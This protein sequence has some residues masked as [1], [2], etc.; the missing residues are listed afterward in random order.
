MTKLQ[1]FWEKTFS[2][3]SRSTFA[4]VCIAHR[5]K[6]RTHRIFFAAR[7]RECFTEHTTR[8]RDII[9]RI[10]SQSSETKE[11]K[12]ASQA[13]RSSV[14]FSI[15]STKLLNTRNAAGN[16]SSGQQVDVTDDFEVTVN[17]KSE[18]SSGSNAK[19]V[20]NS[21]ARAAATAKR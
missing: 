5:T 3:N 16:L 13:K 14:A 21:R 8:R 7:Q 19:K 2:R 12:N 1:L 11:N 17:S 10:I 6:K 9:A 20:R 18:K 4:V 15:S